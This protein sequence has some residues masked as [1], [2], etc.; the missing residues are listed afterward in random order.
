MK[1]KCLDVSR[2]R[3]RAA[4][5]RALETALA[6]PSLD[7][8]TACSRLR[9][10]LDPRPEGIRLAEEIPGLGAEELAR[11][12]VHPREAV[13]GVIERRTGLARPLLERIYEC[14]RTPG[15][16][17]ERLADLARGADPA[18]DEVVAHGPAVP[19]VLPAQHPRRAD[20][21]PDHANRSYELLGLRAPRPTTRM[22]VSM[23]SPEGTSMHWVHSD[24]EPRGRGGDRAASTPPRAACATS[25]STPR[26]GPACST[27]S[28]AD[29]RAGGGRRVSRGRA[30]GLPRGHRAAGATALRGGV[31][32][33]LGGGRHRDRALVQ[34]GDE[35]EQ[36]HDR[37][38]ARHHQP[39]PGQHQ[40][41]MA[42]NGIEVTRKYTV[43]FGGERPVIMAS[44][45]ARRG[46]SPPT[47]L[48]AARRG[49]PVPAGADATSWRRAPS[50]PP[51]PIS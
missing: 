3:R 30:P 42:R 34:G 47:S 44:L 28:T 22:K 36:A 40:R 14:L 27:S 21:A 18:G 25:P 5:A 50:R 49:G 20:G 45:Y 1:K 32:A 12:L 15:D 8:R 46:A 26:T 23:A 33:V 38:P 11:H 9:W 24:S 17:A 29:P 10:L 51:R 6:A 19:R 35:R 41:I 31:A 4:C 2:A 39:L 7:E 43:T 48:R 37:L 13:L 16:D